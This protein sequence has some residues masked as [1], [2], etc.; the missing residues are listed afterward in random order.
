LTAPS[1]VTRNSRIDST[2]SS[3]FLGIVVALPARQAGGHLG[4]DRVA[5][6][7]A[8]TR[9]GV[10]L[11]DLEHP[12]V[13]LTQ[14]THQPGRVGAG[15]LDRDDIDAAERAQP[16]QQ[17]AIAS[18][19]RRERRAAQQGA[20]R[21]ER[22]DLV[23]VAVRIDAVDDNRLAVLHAVHGRPFVADGGRPGRE[24]RTQQ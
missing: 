7:A 21:I 11:V 3:V 6:A 9:V 14:V 22:C 23:R 8:T 12:D 10:G 1:R 2:I 19:R 24:G 15:R 18:E 5:L 17:A 20:T 16:V 4:V 13:V